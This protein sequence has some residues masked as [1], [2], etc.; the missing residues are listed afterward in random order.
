MIIRMTVL[1]CPDCYEEYENEH[2]DEDL[3]MW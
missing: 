2:L 3:E 1:L